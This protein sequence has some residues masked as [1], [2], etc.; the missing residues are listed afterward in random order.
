MT[1]PAITPTDI[2]QNILA[3]VPGLSDSAKAD[4]WDA[5]HNA[6]NADDLG[7]ALQDPKFSAIDDSVKAHLWDAKNNPSTAPQTY[8]PGTIGPIQQPKTTMGKLASWIDNVTSDLQDGGDRTGVGT[9]LQKLGAHGIDSG[10]SAA[11]GDFMASLPLGLLKAAKG[12][13]EMVPSAIGG[14]K[15]NTWRG[16]KDLVGGGLKAISEPAAFVAPEE[17][18]LSD[19]GLLNDAAGAAAKATDA[20]GNAASAVKSAAAPVVQKVADVASGLKNVLTDIPK[21]TESNLVDAIGDAAEN[22]GFDRSD[23]AATLKDAV[24]DLSDKFRGRAQS[25]YQ[26]LDDEAPGFQEL[27]DKIGQLKSAYKV[28]A[29][30]DPSKADEIASTLKDAQSTMSDLLDQGQTARWKQADGD[31]SRYKA[32]QQ[33]QGK[34]NA[35]AT[36]L[37]SDSLNDVGK[38]QSGVQALSNKM[39]K[40][41][42]PIDIV[43]KAFGD[44]A[45]AIRQIVQDAVNTTSNTAAA[46]TLLKWVGGGAASTAGAGAGY[47]LYRALSGGK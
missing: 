38:L 37:T 23:T 13:A 46:K 36:D 33:V 15:G 45:G 29:N 1:T 10:N 47:E 2:A 14:E 9:V 35:A 31:W 40:G 43:S 12:G 16:V 11:V 4:A 30:M 6:S 24:S 32:L 7:T 22:S 20:V 18:A 34:A 39:G 21:E 8:T 28:Q 17:S 27:R 42:N 44:D 5:F 3:S 19:E 26:A 41:G 25:A